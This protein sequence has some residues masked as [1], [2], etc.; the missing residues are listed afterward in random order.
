MTSFEPKKARSRRNEIRD[1]VRRQ[2]PQRRR[3]VTALLR[4]E[5]A[6]L[7]LA[8]ALAFTV[9]AAA[10]LLLRPR[11]VEYR[12]GQVTRAPVV[13]RTSFEVLDEQRLRQA[14]AAAAEAE[15]TV[16]RAADA[17]PV[18]ALQSEL[19]ALPDRVRGLRADQL[20]DLDEPLDDVLDGAR[21]ARLQEAAAGPGARQWAGAT[22]RFA[23]DLASLDLLLLPADAAEQAVP[24]RLPDGRVLNGG[25]YGVAPA[26]LDAGS[27]DERAEIERKLA[28]PAADA[29]SP[30][31]APMVVNYA[32]ARLGPTHVVDEPATALARQSA[33]ARVPEEAGLVAYRAGQ[34]LLPA[35]R[36]VSEGDWQLLRAENAAFRESLGGLVWLERLGLLGCAAILT[37]ALAAYAVRYQPRIARNPTRAAGLAVL[38]LSALLVAQLAGLGTGSTALLGVGPVILAAMVLCVVY[39]GR[40]ALG[41]AG[42]LALLVTLGLGEGVGFYL[43]CFASVLVCC[44]LLGEV[45]TR[46]RLIEVGGLTGLTAGGAALVVGLVGLESPTFTLMQAA[47]AALGGFAAGG[48]VLCVLPVIE[49]VFH[50]TT[51][52]TLLEYQDHPLLRRLALEAPGTYNH[53]LQV[54][55]LSEEAAKAIGAD[56]L[57]CRVACYYHDV[58]KLRK[59]EYF[60]ENQQALDPGNPEPCNPHLALN[61][62]MSLLVI[63]GHVKDGLAMAREWGLPR[64]FLPFIEQHHGTTLVEYFYREACQRQRKKLASGQQG[65]EPEPADTEYR[66]PGPRP[67][68]RETAIVMLADCCESAVRAM[69]EPTPN[70]IEARVDDLC[71]KRLLDRQFDECPITTGE[72]EQVRRSLVKSLVG[73]YHGRVAYPSDKPLDKA[74]DPFK[75]A[76]PTAAAG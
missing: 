4:D 69:A 11:V 63:I 45:R 22:N 6:L 37:A 62:S 46:S 53:S 34:S 71:Q 8:V 3:Q 30:T 26:T 1:E 58:G 72:L 52:L 35:G 20:D 60:I 23:D 18:A 29:F 41:V 21:L 14:R 7:T 50:V 13:A 40:F 24:A 55:N 66:Y 51:G 15:P 5:K 10:V 16:L 56:G 65:A 12:P 54:A 74:A 61:P 32:L 25:P 39:D 68:S 17:E 76:P 19:L 67:R 57:L 48:L 49:R 28:G 38:L 9:T 42:I 70:R 44:F 64:A 2:K 31:L 47:W 75:T 43:V 73:A 33:G 59:P 27:F 36:R